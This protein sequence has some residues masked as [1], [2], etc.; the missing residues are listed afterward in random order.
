MKKKILSLLLSSIILIGLLGC[1][2]EPGPGGRATIKG[3]LLSGN[4]NSPEFEVT[5]EDGEPEERVYLVYG[6]RMSGHDKDMRVSHDGSFEFKHLRKG[7][8]QVFAYGYNP[9]KSSSNDMSPIIRTIEVSG[10]QTAEVNDLIIYKK[11]NKGGTS[12][13]RGKVFAKYFAPGSGQ[14]RGQGYIGDEV[15]Y[16]RFGNSISYDVRIRTAHDGSFEINNLRKG[17]YQIWAF[18]KDSQSPTGETAVIKEV[19]I[20][21]RNQL[22]NL[23]DL[24]INK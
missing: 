9:E 15:V 2:K 10:S 13:I 23:E 5:P 19:E 17:K 1:N 8:Y 6:D 18:S 20:N 3:K 7:V 22:I 24:E 4:I 11:A 21:E 14:L 16:V 12:T